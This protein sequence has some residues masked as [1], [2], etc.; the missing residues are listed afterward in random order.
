MYALTASLNESGAAFDAFA[1][2]AIPAFRKLARYIGID[3][4]ELANAFTEMSKKGLGATAAMKMLRTS[5]ELATIAGTDMN[6]SV[7]IATTLYHV[8]GIKAENMTMRMGQLA[9]AALQS[10][11]NLDEL[12]DVIT[13]SGAGVAAAEPNFENFLFVLTAA[14]NVSGTATITGTQLK[15]MYTKLF[16]E[17]DKLASGFGVATHE[18]EGFDKRLRNIDDIM[19]DMIKSTNG[20]R[21]A[22][23]AAKLAYKDIFGQRGMIPIFGMMKKGIDIVKEFGGATENAKKKFKSMVR[24]TAKIGEAGLDY[25]GKL[26]DVYTE[27]N[28]PFQIKQLGVEFNILSRSISAIALPTL[29]GIVRNLTLV[30]RGLG[31]VIRFLS[32]VVAQSKSAMISVRMMHAIVISIGMLAAGKAA[33]YL[34]GAAWRFFVGTQ[35]EATAAT[36]AVTAG[37]NAQISA[38]QRATVVIG[39]RIIAEKALAAAINARIGAADQA[40]ATDLAFLPVHPGYVKEMTAARPGLFARMSAGVTAALASAGAMFVR[41]GSK[42]P[43]LAKAATKFWGAAKWLWMFL[44]SI[45]ILKWLSYALV[46]LT[47]AMIIFD[48][49]PFKEAQKE[50]KDDVI[51]DALLGGTSNLQQAADHLKGTADVAGAKFMQA[52]ASFEAMTKEE[53]GVFDKKAFDKIGEY[54][55]LLRASIPDFATKFP[56]LH[57]RYAE[58][59]VTSN[60]MIS[61]VLAGEVVPGPVMRKFAE[62]YEIVLGVLKFGLAGQKGPQAKERRDFLKEEEERAKGLVTGRT[63]RLSLAAGAAGLRLKSADEAV[64][65]EK[66]RTDVAKEQLGTTKELINATKE[67]TREFK[68]RKNKT[69]RVG[70]TEDYGMALAGGGAMG[71]DPTHTEALTAMWGEMSKM[72]KMF[73]SG[74]ATVNVKNIGG[75]VADENE[76]NNDSP[77][78]GGM[79]LAKGAHGYEFYD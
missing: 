27:E 30:A 45:P 78:S 3:V 76:D 75:A 4:P 20:S 26:A 44:K 39:E 67:L 2:Q 49:N 7:E 70:M 12:K 13:R 37:T 42:V 50:L 10:R 6:E 68:I 22:I 24:E 48:W 72:V 18:G 54:I 64:K 73:I 60:K 15:V 43:L 38:E 59:V 36:A 51:L 57:K 47:S 40:I 77:A 53:P 32:E 46:G 33:I 71:V 55:R 29:S 69:D 34:L 16:A 14:R 35:V 61:H 25:I 52:A 56:D 9:Y 62:Q 41:F 19:W 11:L 63:P 58:A 5:A 21:E 17:I 31:T 74:D 1:N 28:V 65:Q 66:E 23:N 8:W 79:S